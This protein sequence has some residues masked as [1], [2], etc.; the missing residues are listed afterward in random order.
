MTTATTRPNRI[1]DMQPGLVE[2]SAPPPRPTPQRRTRRSSM[3]WLTRGHAGRAAGKV[4]PIRLA[5]PLL[6]PNGA[7]LW[8]ELGGEIEDSTDCHIGPNT[9]DRWE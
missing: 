6:G 2:V 4:P 1:S 8:I 3:S 7:P 9:F 5:V